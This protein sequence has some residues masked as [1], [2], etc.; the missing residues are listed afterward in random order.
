M[1]ECPWCEY[2]K[3]PC[4]TAERRTCDFRSLTMDR[5][6]ILDRIREESKVIHR[7]MEKKSSAS[8]KEI[9][10][11]M[12]KISGVLI[13]VRVLREKFEM[14]DY[15]I[16][17]LCNLPEISWAERMQLVLKLKTMQKSMQKTRGQKHSVV[18]AVQKKKG[19]RE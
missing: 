8:E 1:V 11:A 7:V 10:Q 14:K 3:Q 16:R 13:M 17:H 15:Q 2:K 4:S 18:Q 6:A 5:A 9:F 19:K 12:D